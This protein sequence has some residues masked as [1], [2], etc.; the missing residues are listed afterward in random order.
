M[1][2]ITKEIQQR[3]AEIGDQ[4]ENK[5]P[6]LVTRFFDPCGTASWY[7]TEYNPE[8]DTCYG[9][10]LWL[11]QKEWR[12]FSISELESIGRPSGLRIERDVDFEEKTLNEFTAVKRII[13]LNIEELKN[14]TQDQEYDRER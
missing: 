14:K 4:S 1:K 9:Y 11:T 13:E 3:F 5:N 2:L 6:I 7:P 8:T 12:T 10:V